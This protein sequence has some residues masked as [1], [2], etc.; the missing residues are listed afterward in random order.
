MSQRIDEI[1]G[2]DIGGAN[3]KAAVW[4]SDQE[5]LG[6][7][8]NF[9]MWKQP[10]RLAD[11]I[12]QLLGSLG[13]ADQ[14]GTQ[15]AVTMTGE[16]ADCF[17]TRREGVVRII[18]QLSQV[19]APGQL[20][21]YT[22]DGRWFTAAQAEQDPWTVAASNWHALASWLAQWPPTSHAFACGVLVD[23]GSTTTD[24]LPV[25]DGRLATDART[26]RDRLERSQLIYTGVRRTPVCAVLPNF[27]LDDVSIPVM[28]ELFA[29]TDDAYVWL[30]LIQEDPNDCDSADGRPR[31]K[32][33][34]AARLA[35][36]IGE[37]AERLSA[38]QL[39]N[40]AQQVVNAQALKVA[41]AIEINLQRVCD[42]FN[43]ASVGVHSPHLI[44]SGHGLP[45]F[46]QTIRNVA[47]AHRVVRLDEHVG[48]QV[49]RSAPA[50]AAAWLLKES[51]QSN[52]HR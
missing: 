43:P 31:T 10:D 35:R 33:H 51:T 44:C 19:V 34:A 25:I 37:D 7:S 3:L 6:A 13:K 15:L 11:G 52:K 5:V 17:A 45:L 2:L 28:A 27:V 29:T 41:R 26:D 9:P 30:G 47:I 48:E 8:L 38:S 40:L 21:I 42:S 4:L 50:A 36:M 23:I 46:G 32:P 39:H 22:V 16:L 20:H 18:D 24:I 49:S 1:V 12:Q 14:V